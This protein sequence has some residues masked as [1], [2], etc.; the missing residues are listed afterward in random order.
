LKEQNFG[1]Y[2]LDNTEF[3]HMHQ[4][5]TSFTFYRLDQLERLE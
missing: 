2:A 4:P 3:S 1:D 5:R